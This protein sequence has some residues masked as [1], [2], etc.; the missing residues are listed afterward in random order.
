MNY[1]DYHNGTL[2]AE[3]VPLT[4]I[5]DQFGT[6][7]YV[8]SRAAIETNWRAFDTAFGSYPHRICYA[9]K[10]NSNIAVLNILAKQQ[11]GF[12][13]VSQGELERVLAAGGDPKK[14]VF[15]GVG[16][17]SAEIQRAIE[18]GIFCFDVE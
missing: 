10:A 7:C 18:V 9:V 17:T 13:I 6:P 5:A 14:I 3:K 12:D 15:S 11:S 2:H 1:F 4:Q 8:Y 16:K